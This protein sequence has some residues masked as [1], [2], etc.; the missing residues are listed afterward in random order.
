MLL[1]R[2]AAEHLDE[3]ENG[4]TS[5]K[6]LARAQESERRADLVRQAVMIEKKLSAAK[7]SDTIET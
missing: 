3:S 1:L 5:E 6:F 7:P 4:N 2:H